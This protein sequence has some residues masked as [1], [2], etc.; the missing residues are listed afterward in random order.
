MATAA[1]I[2][3]ALVAFARAVPILD[4]WLQQFVAW[5]TQTQMA[6]MKKENRDAVIQAVK[7]HDQRPIEVVIGNPNAGEPSGV[8]GSIIGDNPPPGVLR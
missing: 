5:Y 7:D 1:S 6:S 8:P 4:S 3:G 2:F